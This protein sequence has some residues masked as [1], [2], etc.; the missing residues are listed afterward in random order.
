MNN[1]QLNE[2][3]LDRIFHDS[4]EEFLP[5]VRMFISTAQSVAASI[6]ARDFA[7]KPAALPAPVVPAPSPASQP[8]DLL[9]REQA[10]ELLLCKPDWIF[11]NRRELGGVLIAGKL[12][13]DRRKLAAYVEK[14]A[15]SA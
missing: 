9:S 14:M 11:R 1:E 13:F 15:R 6:H 4:D 10:A 2:A 12:R 8:P 7:R 5:F 3:L